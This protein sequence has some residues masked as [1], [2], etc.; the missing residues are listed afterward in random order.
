MR[1]HF[2]TVII[3]IAYAKMAQA[4]AWVQPLGKGLLITQATY[5]STDS[6]FDTNGE[7][8][9]QP[10]FSKYELQPYGEYGLNDWLTI[11]G[12]AYAQSVSQSGVNNRGIADPEI[13]A[14]ARLWH[15]DTQVISIQPLVKFSSH[16]QRGRPPQ[17]GSKTRDGELSI[18]YGRNLKILSDRDYVDSRVGYRARDHGLSNQVRSDVALGLNVS[19]TVQIVPALRTVIA[20]DMSEA[21]TFTEGGDLD[22]NVLKAEVTGIYHMNDRQWLQASLFKHVAGIQTGAGYGISLG[23]AESF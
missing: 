12:S 15:S 14:R 18:L 23:F 19:D 6:Y 21:A 16:F 2:V 10:R 5:Y 7:K 4:G 9:S 22:Y 17:G 1:R 20:T 11:G 13:F 8:Q 3:A